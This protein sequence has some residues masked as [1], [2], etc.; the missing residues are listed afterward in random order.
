MSKITLITG[1]SRGIGRGIALELA[2][3]GWTVVIN[4]RKN[5]VAATETQKKIEEFGSAAVTIQADITKPRDRRKL[6]KETLALY[7]GIDLLVNNVGRAPLKRV[8]LL[9]V[10][11]ESFRDVMTTNLEGP[12]FLTQMVANHMVDLVKT[13]VIKNPK[14]INI[15]SISAYTSSPTRAEYCLSKAGISMMTSLFADRLAEFGI[16]V[17]E[18]RPGII[19]TDM[20]MPVKEKYDRLIRN[21]LT[22]IERWG[23]PEDVGK[24]VV[25]I[26][27]GYLTFSTG[28]I[29][30]VD[31]GFHLR[32]L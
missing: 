30:N 8:D 1:A 2:K 6:I 12:F 4:F 28:E 22:P 11:K 24:A 7:H 26:S 10:S 32:R 5:Q 16:G 17:F 3:H 29:I 23:K 14:I 31:G 21:G 18:I 27:E 19:E 25:A 20:T 13:G 15:S 9:N